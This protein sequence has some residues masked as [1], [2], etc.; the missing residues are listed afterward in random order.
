[1]G[2]DRFQHV[3]PRK[4]QRRDWRAAVRRQERQTF[5]PCT[6]GNA[7][8]KTLQNLFINAVSPSAAGGMP[9]SR[10]QTSQS[11]EANSNSTQFPILNYQANSNI[12][13]Q[14]SRKAEVNQKKKI[15][16]QK[17]NSSKLYNYV[18]SILGGI[19]V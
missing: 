12:D 18:S 4:T 15:N 7:V 1:M 16:R 14:L 9:V 3:S 19:K 17:I 10:Y 8:T 13:V 2:S 6:E 11:E 5:K